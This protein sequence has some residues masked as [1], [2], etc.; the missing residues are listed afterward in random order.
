MVIANNLLSQFTARQLNINTGNKAK[1]AEKLSSG[2]RINRASDDAA[3]LKISEKMRSQIRGLTRGAQNTQEGI[4]WIQTADGAM[5]EILDMVQRI[6]ELS[7]QA[8]NDTNSIAERE[9]INSEIKQLKSEINRVGIDTEFNKQPVFQNDVEMRVDGEMGDLQIFNSSYDAQ[10]GKVEYGGFIFAGN[11]VTW[12]TL[13]P[14]MVIVDGNNKQIFTGG[15]Y[16]YVEPNTGA[17][18]ELVCNAGDEVPRITRKLSISADA[19]GVMIDKIKHEWSEFRNVDDYVWELDHEGLT[20]SFF[21]PDEQMGLPQA[22]N[23]VSKRYTWNITY[24]GSENVRAVDASVMKNIRLSNY[25][26]NQMVD[27][28]LSYTVK[29]D[30]DGIWLETTPDPNVPGQWEA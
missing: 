8:S 28:N 26:A 30:D 12:D 25:T 6:R 7:V 2:Y 1:T 20:L 9:A 21:V 29:A 27:N 10:T 11:R 23:E 3:G 15:T 24:T 22:M 19:S 5:E 17:H 13:S 4:S 14:G 18:F 16:E